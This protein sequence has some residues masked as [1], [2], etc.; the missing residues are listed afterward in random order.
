[1]LVESHFTGT[2]NFDRVL[3]W[4]N[5]DIQLMRA[6]DCDANA[7][8]VIKDKYQIVGNNISWARDYGHADMIIGS[9]PHQLYR[10]PCSG[11]VLGIS[12]EWRESLLRVRQARPSWVVYECLMYAPWNAVC[13]ELEGM[14][15]VV[16]VCNVRAYECGAPHVRARVFLLAAK[17]PLIIHAPFYK[18]YK[19]PM[20]PTPTE[21]MD[22]HSGCYTRKGNTNLQNW[23]SKNPDIQA[24]PVEQW[25]QAIGWKPANNDLLNSLVECAGEWLMGFTNNAIR[26]YHFSHHT[27][28]RLIGNATLPQQAHIGLWR[29]SLSVNRLLT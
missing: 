29:A 14:G 7:R 23:V 28:C 22:I 10:E 24:W 9:P 15:Y 3:S 26:K 16:R 21:M 18:R 13:D 27:A 19:G 20:M 25:F 5:D 1:M 4:V 11:R 12:A 17:E 6:F 8:E 2:G